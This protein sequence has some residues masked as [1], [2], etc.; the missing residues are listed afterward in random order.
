MI[1]SHP[2]SGVLI[3]LGDITLQKEEAK[4]LSSVDE[5]QNHFNYNGMKKVL[6]GKPNGKFVPKRI[7]VIQMK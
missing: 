6:C 5:Y 1:L 4:K 3:T 7:L 2:H